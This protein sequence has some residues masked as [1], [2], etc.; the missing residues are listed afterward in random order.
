MSARVGAE[1]QSHCRKCGVTWHVVIAVVD[2]R[3]AQVECGECGAR[4]RHRP[5]EGK[6]GRRAAPASARRGRRSAAQAASRA[7]VAADP[8]RPR[9]PFRDSDTYQV[10]DRIVHASFGEGVVQAV[11]G[12]TKV[13]VLFDVGTKTL[14]QGRGGAARE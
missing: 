1:V 11:K 3:I 7:V 4:H 12:P 8:S 10:G 9:R 5:V 14:V 2:A 13:Q 6:T